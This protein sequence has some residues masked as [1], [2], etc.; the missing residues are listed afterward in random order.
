MLMISVCSAII[1][2]KAKQLK[3]LTLEWSQMMMGIRQPPCYS[4]FCHSDKIS[5]ISNLQGGKLTLAHFFRSFGPWSVGSKSGFIEPHAG[6][7]EK[8]RVISRTPIFPSK[9]HP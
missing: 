5:E 2:T 7:A 1:K 8:Q 6:Q 9:A 4:A 3:Q